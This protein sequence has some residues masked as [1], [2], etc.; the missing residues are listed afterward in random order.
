M[1]LPCFRFSPRA[2]RDQIA[3]F[4]NAADLRRPAFAVI[5]G[6]QLTDAKPGAQMLGCA[7]ALIA[8]CESA[9]IPMTDVLTKAARALND[10][11][12][13]YSTHVRAI[14]DYAANEIAK[15]E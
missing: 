14:R 8:M 11:E 5:D 10:A 13:P 12:G 2:V 6:L 9:N 1:R 3:F 7:A 15:G 4:A